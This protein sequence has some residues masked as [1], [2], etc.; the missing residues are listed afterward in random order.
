MLGLVLGRQNSAFAEKTR[1]DSAMA[2]RVVVE[3]PDKFDA[4][5]AET[6]GK[7]ENEHDTFYVYFFSDWCPDCHKGAHA[8]NNST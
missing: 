6:V 1:E 8:S 3:G 5:V 7:L 4:A 2:Q